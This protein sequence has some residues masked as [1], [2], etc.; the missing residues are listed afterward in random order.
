MQ[1]PNSKKLPLL[2]G[3]TSNIDLR[4]DFKKSQ[5]FK[6]SNGVPQ[7]CENLSLENNINNELLKNDFNDLSVNDISKIKNS[8]NSVLPAWVKYDRQ[9]L[10]FYSYIIEDVPQ[11]P[12]ETSRIRKCVMYFYLEDESIHVTESKVENS[13]MTQ[14]VFLRRHRIPKGTSTFYSIEDFQIGGEIKCYGRSFIVYDC[15]PFTRKF[16][17]EV[18]SPLNPSQ[19]CPVDA[20]SAKHTKSEVTFH[21]KQMNSL[22]TYMEASLGKPIGQSA[23]SIRRFFEHDRQVLRF[24]ALWGDDTL[25]G[26][27]RPF[28]INYYLADDAVEVLEVYGANSGRDPFPSMLKK[29]RLPKIVTID[30]LSLN[31]EDYYTEKDFRVG[32]VISV[33][34]RAMLIHA[35]DE[36]TKGWLIENRGCTEA[37]F[38]TI[39]AKEDKKVVKKVEI[40]PYTG[41]GTEEDSLQSVKNLVPKPPKKEIKTDEEEKQVTRVMARLIS[42]RPED[43]TR[44]FV[45]SLYGADDSISVFERPGRNSGFVGGKFLEKAKLKNPS[46]GLYYKP[47]DLVIGTQLNVNSYIFDLV[48]PNDV[49]DK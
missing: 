19:E 11:S 33:L 46:T 18:G 21:G 5:T 45:I 2:P 49:L 26:E 22:K 31:D 37:D 29:S 14:G 47:A 8:N 40:P 13:G 43:V 38:P 10:R 30:R 48:D 36:Y 25:Y 27:Q 1:S 23:E 41:Y 4:T 39:I 17:E 28:V 9:V 20:Y 34:G 24:Y 44:L 3:Y 6:V 16:Y 42:K 12:T 32:K 35:C 15:D 7:V